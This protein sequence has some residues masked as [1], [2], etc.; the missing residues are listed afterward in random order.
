MI[1][2]IIIGKNSSLTKSNLKYIKN[3]LVYSANNLNLEE[4][5][6][7]IKKIKKINIIF[8]NFYPSKF[9]NQLNYQSYNQF[10]NLSLEKIFLL[11]ENLPLNKINKIIY[12]SSS[13]VYRLSESISNEKPDRFNRQLYSSFKLAA[14]KLIMNYANKNNKKYFIMRLFNTYGDEKDDFSFVEKII[15]AK[16][17]SNKITLINDGLSL[18]DY[19]HLDDIG[20]IYELFLKKNFDNGI[21]DIGTGNGTLIKNLVKVAKIKEDKITRV[22]KIEEIQNSIADNKK[23]LLQIPNFKFRKVSQYI[24]RKLSLKNNLKTP[25]ISYSKKTI[26]NFTGVAIYGAG[27]AGKQIYKELKKNNEN[28]LYFIDDNVKIQNSIYNGVPIISYGD[29]LKNDLNLQIKRVYLSIPSLSKKSLN[30][31]IKR[32][33]ENFI[34]VRF[35]PEKKFLLSDRIDLNDLNID[36]VNEILKRKQVK[37]KKIKKLS[38]KVILVTGAGGTIGSEICRQLIQQKVKRII[39]VDKSEIAI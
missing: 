36:E 39:A 17:N 23:L 26:P 38:N 12:T 33:K 8:N 18:R 20:K 35:L 28:I 31:I 9:L 22:N 34:D 21:Y 16:K 1:K 19:V 27:F 15:R 37:I 29:V 25:I 4:L 13:A 7:D 5:N 32:L 10:R 30:V 6:K 14:E 2:N 24:N 11:F 3:C